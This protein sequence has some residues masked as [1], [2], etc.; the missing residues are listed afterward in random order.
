M[1][2]TP[3]PDKGDLTAY[4]DALFRYASDGV[5][6]AHRAY[7]EG[8]PS[9]CINRSVTCIGAGDLIT[10]AMAAATIAANYHAP[11]VYCPPLAGFRAESNAAESALVEAYTITVDCDQYPSEARRLLESCIGPATVVVTTGGLWTDS[12]SGEVQEKLHL[13]W[14]LIEYATGADLERLKAARKLATQKVGGDASGVSL[15]HCF[16]APGSWHRKGYPKLAKI[17][18]I[19]QG[20]EIELGDALESLE[21]L[22]H[23][24]WVQ[25][26]A[27]APA[28]PDREVGHSADSPRREDVVRALGGFWDYNNYND[29]TNAAL[30][31]HST[32]W[33]REE[34]F[35][36]SEKSPKFDLAENQRKWAQTVP[37]R[38]ITALSILGRVPKETLSTWGRDHV[39]QGRID[40]SGMGIFQP[41]NPDHLPAAG[42][43]I[44][45]R[46]Q[47]GRP[48]AEIGNV[49]AALCDPSMSGADARFD[50]FRAELM[51][52]PT[53]QNAWKP[54]GDGDVVELR[55][56]LAAQGFRPVG[57]EMM[58]DALALVARDQQFDS[59]TKWLEYEVP[60]WD[61]IPRIETALSDHFRVR[62]EPYT[63]AVAQ[64]LFTAMAGRVLSP[65][66]QAD[67]VV[68]LVGGQGVGKSTAA[69][70]LSPN[71]DFFGELSFGEKDADQSRAIRGKLILELSELRGLKTRD[72]ESIK[73]LI[74]RRHERWTPKYK[75]YETSYPRRCIFIGTTNSTEF[76]ADETGERR[77]LPV[78]VE[79]Q[80]DINAL[81]AAMPQLWA[82]ARDLYG[83]HGVIWQKAQALAASQHIDFKDRDPWTD[84]V[85]EWLAGKGHMGLAPPSAMTTVE[86]L[87][88]V[89]GFEARNVGQREKQRIAKIM[90]ENGFTLRSVWQ[91]SRSI[92]AWVFDRGPLTPSHESKEGV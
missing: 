9:Q 45:S 2:T 15:A 65:G 32:P 72:A 50:T 48:K 73:G 16:R 74:T 37:T 26:K 88:G 75:E 17:V 33:G 84:N 4:F 28:Y 55:V 13:H 6:V 20:A 83:R 29:W 64:Y 44:Y 19:N 39:G 41:R 71:R 42:Q 35:R 79:G 85:V 62:D 70:A 12:E 43:H 11:A 77:W 78:R 8:Q 67:M 47:H 59:A 81:K 86:I 69:A 56:R 7:T 31:L 76:L 57:R 23:A 63:R 25:A 68:I 18:T 38:G 36:W 5:Y 1:T 30:A 58:R 60:S 3:T 10:D 80:I 91:E 14:R 53:G 90:R 24:P 82:E 52:S 89:L 49:V 34:W 51:I 46:D 61:G 21:E 27:L 66:C 22:R 92:W 40:V 87:I 54:L